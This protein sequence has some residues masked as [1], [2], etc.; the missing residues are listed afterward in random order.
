MAAPNW[1]GD[2]ADM[3]SNSRLV[4][5]GIT[6]AIGGLLALVAGGFAGATSPYGDQFTGCLKG[7]V[8]S[9][10]KIGAFPTSPCTKPAVKIS[11]NQQGPAGP[12]GPGFEGVHTVTSPVVTVPNGLNFGT[13]AQCDN[14]TEIAISGGIEPTIAWPAGISMTSVP[15]GSDW[16]GRIKNDSGGDVSYIVYAVCAPLG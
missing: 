3:G 13:V 9:K 7:G 10:V 11:W 4:R 5:V 2:V 16:L 12:R 1:E 15:L 6:L 14:S 8:I